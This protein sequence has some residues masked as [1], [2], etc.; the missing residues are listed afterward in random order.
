MQETKLEPHR[1]EI[2]ITETAVLNDMAHAILVLEELSEMGVHISL[3]DFGTGYS[4]LSYLHKLPLDKIKIDKSFVDDL[5]S[6]ERS[7]T[8][9]SGITAMGRALDLKLVVEGIESQQQFDLLRDHYN[10]DYMQGYFFSKALPADA[11]REFAD[12]FNF[13]R[14]VAQTEIE[15]DQDNIN[16]EVA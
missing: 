5:V 12:S 7:K 13:T 8:L 4:S 1:L 3:D 2:E 16:R 15:A 9:L 14:S 11:A 10:V 6:S